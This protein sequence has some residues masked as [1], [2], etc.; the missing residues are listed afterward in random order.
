MGTAFYGRVFTMASDCTEPK[1]YFVLAATANRYSSEAGIL[2]NPEIA[3]IIQERGLGPKLYREEAVKVVSWDNH[4]VAYN[5]EQ[6]FRMKADL[7]K[8]QCITS[9]MTWAVSHDDLDGTNSKALVFAIG[10]P[11]AMTPQKQTDS[12][13]LI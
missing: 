10:L 9:F 12:V 7:V 2:L 5:N 1:C 8:S 3:E 13:G 4:W 11:S 6:T